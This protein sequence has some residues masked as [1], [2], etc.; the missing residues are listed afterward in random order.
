MKTRIFSSI[1]LAM[2]IATVS[3]GMSSCGNDEPTSDGTTSSRTDETPGG[4]GK[5]TPQEPGEG[6][7]GY[8]VVPQTDHLFKDE[9][10]FN[11]FNAAGGKATIVYNFHSYPHFD[12]ATAEDLLPKEADGTIKVAKKDMEGKD[13]YCI[14]THSNIALFHS[15]DVIEGNNYLYEPDFLKE[16]KE[17]G[18]KVI[19]ADETAK[20]LKIVAGENDWLNAEINFSS[21]TITLNILPN[22][23]DKDRVMTF[24][25][26]DVY[27][28]ASPTEY[29]NNAIR[30]EQSCK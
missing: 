14:F 11:T 16:A 5:D 4:D 27:N 23:T 2:V 10:I 24:V 25:M 12:F 7:D 26:F 3:F 18:I 22:D 8:E 21:H 17:K 1:L 9:D 19:N 30:I 29:V 20:T 28:L 13:A 15:G 6:M